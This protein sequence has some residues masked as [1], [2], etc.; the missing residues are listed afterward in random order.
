M[1]SNV[2]RFVRASAGGW[3]CDKS[4]YAGQLGSIAAGLDAPHVRDESSLSSAK[5]G[6]PTTSLPELARTPPP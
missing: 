5:V 1:A 3:D 6:E 4:S 2:N